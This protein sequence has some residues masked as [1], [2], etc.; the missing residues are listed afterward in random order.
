MFGTGESA[1]S[2]SESTMPSRT[3]SSWTVGT[4]W[5]Q[6]GSSGDL[7]RS[8]MAGEIRNSKFSA[9]WRSRST[10]ATCSGPKRAASCSSDEM[11]FLRSSSCQVSIPQVLEIDHQVVTRRVI[12]RNHRGPGVAACLVE[13]PRGGVILPPRGLHDDEPTAVS[14]QQAFDLRQEPAPDAASMPGRVHDDPVQVVR[15]L[16]AWPGAPAGVAHEAVAVVRADE[17]VVIVASQRLVEQLDRGGDL[18]L[19]EDAR[20]PRER[21]K[22]CALGA[23]DGAERAAH[24]RPS[25]PAPRAAPPRRSGAPA[26]RN[27][28]R[29]PWP[30]AP[31]RPRPS[32]RGW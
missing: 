11:L 20:G 2:L 22:P 31:A 6:I 28:N 26:P 4:Y 16:R 24:A 13:P 32:G 30:C 3:S 5:R 27:P 23:A 18:R 21:L 7:I 10:S 9:A 12:R 8:T 15:A 19:A 25:G 14:R 1:S 29:S 17:P